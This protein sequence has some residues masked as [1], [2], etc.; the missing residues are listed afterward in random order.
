MWSLHRLE[1]NV[2]AV[3]VPDDYDRSLL[4]L[5]VQEYSD[6]PNPRFRGKN[7]DMLEYIKW[8]SSGESPVKTGY[9]GE[10]SDG[11]FTYPVD[12]AGFNVSYKTAIRCYKTL[13]VRLMTK[14]DHEFVKILREIATRLGSLDACAYIIGVDSLESY[15]AQHEHNHARYYT[16]KTYRARVNSALRKIPPTVYRKLRQNLLDIGYAEHVI[17]DEIHAYLRGRDW[18]HPE[19][20]KGVPLKTLRKIHLHFSS[21]IQ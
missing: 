16:D 7:F 9:P 1:P 11:M 20:M 21:A 19:F 10:G 18:N 5:R 17:R 14:Y 13:P 4:F 2:F 8:Y 15:T 3:V 6:S 12:W